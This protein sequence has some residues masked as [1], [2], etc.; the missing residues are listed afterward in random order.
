MSSRNPFVTGINPMTG[1]QLMHCTAEDRIR[2][3]RRFNRDQCMQAMQIKGLQ[4]TV[5]AAVARR[6]RQLEPEPGQ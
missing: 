4:K 1:G 3:V 5:I 2:A 6:L